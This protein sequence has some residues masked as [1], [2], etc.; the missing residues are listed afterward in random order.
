MS[1]LPPE[2]SLVHALPGR[3]RLRFE[4]QQRDRVFLAA[5]ATALSAIEGITR[6]E[7]RPSTGSLIIWHS[8]SLAHIESVAEARK[9]FTI[10]RVRPAGSPQPPI[11]MPN[12]KALVTAAMGALAVWQVSRGRILPPALTL[13][14]YAIEIAGLLIEEDTASADAGSGE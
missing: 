2:A 6:V 4:Q 10:D 7:T 12:R 11:S 13:A 9:L 8:A 1:D 5:I 3:V 14:M